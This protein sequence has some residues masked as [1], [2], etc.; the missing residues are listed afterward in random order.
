MLYTHLDRPV[1]EHRASL[2]A[3]SKT[4]CV[5][6]ASL[7]P[8][9]LPCLLATIMHSMCK[10]IISPVL[11]WPCELFQ[12]LHIRSEE[13]KKQRQRE[14]D[15]IQRATNKY[16][17]DQAKRGKEQ[18]E[19]FAALRQSREQQM[20]E[21]RCELS[22]VFAWSLFCE[23]TLSCSLYGTQKS[24]YDANR[25]CVCSSISRQCYAN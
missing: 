23:S 3:D 25:S 24:N 1:A 20:Q 21:F 8:R 19:K 16:Q 11:V 18:K 17:E 22:S 13:E 2:H 15:M 10:V 5:Q 4:D 12:E 9:C 7:S 6:P 14:S